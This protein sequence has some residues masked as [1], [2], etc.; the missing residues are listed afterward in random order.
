MKKSVISFAIA[1]CFVFGAS[2]AQAQAISAP[3]PAMEADKATPFTG[4]GLNTPWN[5]C[6]QYVGFTGE[7][8]QPGEVNKPGAKNNH[9][10]NRDGAI[11]PGFKNDD[12]NRMPEFRRANA[13]LANNEP[14]NSKTYG[15]GKD[16][17]TT[18]NPQGSGDTLGNSHFTANSG[19]N[20]WVNK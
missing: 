12:G 5:C 11:D 4:K 18:G 15:A 7:R 17:A 19:H 3:K 8:D 14:T 9:S 13:V 20:Q 16:A 10:R 1:S 6:K 2:L